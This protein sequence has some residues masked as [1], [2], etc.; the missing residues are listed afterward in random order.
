MKLKDIDIFEVGSEIQLVGAVYNSRDKTYLC[1][2][3]EEEKKELVL[4]DM[5]REDW[6]KFIKQSDLLERQI[7]TGS[8][9]AIFRKTQRLI[10]AHMMWGVYKRDNYHCRYCGRSGV[11]LSVDHLILFE[12]GGPTILENLL[13]ACKPCNRERGSM[14][15]KDWIESDTYA[16][17]SVNLSENIKQKNIELIDTLDNIE[18]LDSIRSR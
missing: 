15:Y 16:N 1:L 10:E 8:Q 4:L 18:R 12:E 5:N 14:Q 7:D 6:K 11:P 2:L 17:R 13:T 9:K 3:P